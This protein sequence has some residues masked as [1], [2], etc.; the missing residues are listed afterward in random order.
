MHPSYDPSA[1]IFQRL[2]ANT[3]DLHERIESRLEIF[4]P[5][6][7]VQTYTRLLERF[8]GFWQPL[9]TELCKLSGL[10]AST[11]DLES[12]LKA[13]LLEADLRRLGAEP[14]RLAR[15]TRLPGVQTFFAGLGCMYVLE[16]STLGAQF[17]ARHLRERFGIDESSGGAFFNAYGGSAGKRWSDF[18]TFLISHAGT[19]PDD[20]IVGA[21]R[22]TFEALD[23]WLEAD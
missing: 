4:S 11:L 18:R 15:C 7:D 16:G 20:E 13:H 23:E 14:E 2:K 6:Y 9:E 3:A 19:G 5:G 17:I 21:A 10:A 8:Y 1:G 12:R 22:E